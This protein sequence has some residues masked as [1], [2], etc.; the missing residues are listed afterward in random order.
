MARKQ[1]QLHAANG[2]ASVEAK[3]PAKVLLKTATEG[4]PKPRSSQ[5]ERRLQE[6][7]A[8]LA[9]AKDLTIR[10]PF[11]PRPKG[12]QGSAWW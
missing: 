7:K 6:I 1:R 8:R 11:E 12:G 4:G 10:T 2:S 9:E 3:A 5:A